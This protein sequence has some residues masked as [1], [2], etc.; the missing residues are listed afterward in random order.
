MALSIVGLDKKGNQVGDIPFS[1]SKQNVYL[2]ADDVQSLSVPS[3][4]NT[5]IISVEKP[6]FVSDATF[7]LPSNTSFASTDLTLLQ[8]GMY[9]WTIVSETS[10]FLRSRYQGDIV[11]MFYKFGDN[12]S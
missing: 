9:S 5:A 11:V 4:Y 3:G 8:I 7:T 1:D 6:T 2:S 10:L 12:R